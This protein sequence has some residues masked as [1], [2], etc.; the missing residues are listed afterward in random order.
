MIGTS[1][2]LKSALLTM[3]LI[4]SILVNAVIVEMGALWSKERG[5][6]PENPEKLLFHC[7]VCDK[8]SHK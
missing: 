1:F 6:M 4:S 3:P 7:G 8:K 2:A 5:E